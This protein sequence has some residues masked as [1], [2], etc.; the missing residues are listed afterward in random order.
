[1]LPSRAKKKK[2]AK[3]ATVMLPVQSRMARAGLGLQVVEIAKLA[4]VAHT[5][6]LRFERGEELKP[7][8]VEAIQRAYELAGIEFTNGHAPGVRLR[9]NNHSV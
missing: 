8:T 2:P 5:T 6:I 4:K 9:A 7:R 3:T 1:M